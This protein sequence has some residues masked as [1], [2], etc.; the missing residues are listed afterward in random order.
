M[1]RSGVDHL[2]NVG[3]RVWSQNGFPNGYDAVPYNTVLANAITTGDYFYNNFET[4]QNNNE[5]CF[6]TS[7]TNET[8]LSGAPTNAS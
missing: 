8:L 1:Y 2:F 7:T 4:H 6:L 5:I 3:F